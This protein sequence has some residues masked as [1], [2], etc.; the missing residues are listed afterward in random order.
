MFCFNKI[1]PSLPLQ[2]YVKSI[3]LIEKVAYSGKPLILVPDGFPEL[4]IN[5]NK[6]FSMNC[7][8]G[9]HYFLDSISALGQLSQ[10]AELKGEIG[11]QGIFVKFYPW[12]Y[13][14][15]LN[16]PLYEIL[17]ATSL[18]TDVSDVHNLADFHHQVL[19]RE[20]LDEK[21]KVIESFLLRNILE[22]SRP[23]LPFVDYALKRMLGS[24]GALPMDE[25]FQSVKC[26]R[27]YIEKQFKTYL[28]LPPSKYRS[29]LRL[30]EVSRRIA[31][32]EFQTFGQ[33]AMEAGFH[34][35]A[36]FS[37]HFLKHVG[38]SPREYEVYMRS[39]PLQNKW[40]YLEQFDYDAE[41]LA[42]R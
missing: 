23:T 33:L 19:E 32:G 38:L 10:V 17:D 18:M 36:H 21:V 39:F 25:Y 14:S 31:Q 6:G 8:D 41:A 9:T 12:T 1:E 4:F 35:A 40:K 11:S 5:L 27:R 29:I 13:Y 2:T 3:W 42:L 34:D 16:A 22:P 7:K 30:K 20:G 26:S 37:N 15:L 24:R 28:G